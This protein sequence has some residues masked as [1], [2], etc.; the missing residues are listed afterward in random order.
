MKFIQSINNV[1]VWVHSL[2]EQTCFP[3][4]PFNG[5]PYLCLLVNFHYH[6]DDEFESEFAKQLILSNCDYVCCAGI[7]SEHWH[8]S[9]DEIAVWLQTQD[10][11]ADEDKYF[12]MTT[13]HDDEEADET[14]N[15]IFILPLID[16]ETPKHYLIMFLG[17]NP[18]EENR[19]L[20][21]IRNYA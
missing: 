16:E 10:P 8:D 7:E 21:G 2:P 18:A 12:L 13:W 5:E 1:S 4:L 17:E 15:F 11:D 14:L 20:E 6:V 3:E 9:I 19:Y